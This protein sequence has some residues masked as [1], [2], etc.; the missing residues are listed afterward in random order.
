[1]ENLSF[2]QLSA[3]SRN[4]K[5]LKFTDDDLRA[6]EA[7]ILANPAGPVMKGTGGLR[8][9]R[10]AARSSAAGKS[11]GARVCY[12]TFPEFGLVYLCAVYAK[13]DKANLTTSEAAAYRAVLQRFLQY[14]RQ[15]YSSKGITP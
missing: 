6:L 4:W 14:L 12:A 10:F 11:G 1:M 7:V 13:T 8:K 9:M 3:F 5:S 15:N 2:I